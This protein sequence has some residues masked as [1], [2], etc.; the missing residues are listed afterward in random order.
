LTTNPAPATSVN[1]HGDLRAMISTR[2]V[3]CVFRLP[4][5]DRPLSLSQ[6][7]EACACQL[8]CRRNADHQALAER[9]Q[10]EK[11]DGVVER[12]ASSLGSFDAP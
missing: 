11:E 2:S 3:R 5:T 7:L 4:R 9:E 8:K 6:R 12:T 1:G 10:D